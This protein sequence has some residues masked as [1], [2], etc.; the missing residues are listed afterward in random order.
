MCLYIQKGTTIGRNTLGSGGQD[1]NLRSPTYEDG[2]IDHF[3][4]PGYV[5]WSK[6]ADWLPQTK[7]L[8]LFGKILQKPEIIVSNCYIFGDLMF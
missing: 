5:S 4:T 6:V 7:L 2:E 3:S 1:S 8:F